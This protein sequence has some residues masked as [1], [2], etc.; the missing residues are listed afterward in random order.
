MLGMPG[1]LN[2]VGP[3]EKTRL[4]AFRIARKGRDALRLGAPPCS[5][6][7]STSIIGTILG[8]ALSFRPPRW[9][10][11]RCR[12]RTRCHRTMPRP[13]L[14]VGFPQLRRRCC[15]CPRPPVDQGFAISARVR[16]RYRHASRASGCHT[17]KPGCRFAERS[18]ATGPHCRR[19]PSCVWGAAVVFVYW[20]DG[21][22]GKVHVMNVDNGMQQ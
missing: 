22:G 15:C 18:L 5:S 12:L 21:D 13:P 10:A 19:S 1:H 11:F 20:G 6:P 14:Y 4:A 7:P 17:L 8:C 9:L 2:R 3:H 16:P